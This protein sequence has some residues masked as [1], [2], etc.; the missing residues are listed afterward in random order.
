[1]LSASNI[2]SVV[3]YTVHTF[4]RIECLTLSDLVTLVRS[5]LN[6]RFRLMNIYIVLFTIGIELLRSSPAI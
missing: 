6:I 4:L 5:A 2:M 1:M 3:A